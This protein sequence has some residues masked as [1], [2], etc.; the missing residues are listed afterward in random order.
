MLRS[1]TRA[2]TPELQTLIDEIED[3][4]MRCI[5]KERRDASR[6]PITRSVKVMIRGEHA[7]HHESITR[8]IS[9]IGIGLLGQFDVET[10]TIAKLSIDRPNRSPSVVLAECRWCDRFNETWHLSGWHFIA[11]DTP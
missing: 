8:D 3:E 10:G 6:L 2:A 11:V 9:R 1:S 4:E 5:I 7:A